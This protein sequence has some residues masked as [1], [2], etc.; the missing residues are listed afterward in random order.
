[1]FHKQEV[2]LEVLAPERWRY[3]QAET[4]GTPEIWK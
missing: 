2:E 3:A 1:M 4:A